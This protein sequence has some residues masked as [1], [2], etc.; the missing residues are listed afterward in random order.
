MKLIR[1]L[2]CALILLAAVVPLYGQETICDDGI[3]NDGDTNVDC[4]DFFDCLFQP[5]SDGV[6]CTTGET[7]R[8]AGCTG[9]TPDDNLCDDGASCTTDTCDAAN[10][11]QYAPNHGLC[12]DSVACTSPDLCDPSSPAAGANGCVNTPN[13]ALCNDGVGCTV[14]TCHPV[15]D[16][17]FAPNDTLCDDGN[18]CTQDTCNPVTDCENTPLTGP[19][20][21]D[22]VGCTLNDVCSAG[23]CA[24]TPDDALCDDGLPC[25]TDTCH[26]TLGCRNPPTPDGQ[27]CDDGWTCTTGDVCTGGVC[28]GTPD[29]NLCGGGASCATGTCDPADPQA[30]PDGCLLSFAPDGTPCGVGGAECRRGECRETHCADQVDNDVDGGYDCADPDDCDKCADPGEFCNPASGRCEEA[31]C[32]DR[33]DNDG[34]RETDCEDDNCNFQPCN[35]RIACTIND[36]CGGI[37]DPTCAGTPDNSQCA[38]GIACTRNPCRPNDPDADR[39]G[40]VFIPEHSRCDDGDP[41]TVDTCDLVQGCLHAPAREIC[42]DGVDNDCDGLTDCADDDCL[43]DADGDGHQAMPCGGDCDDN[44]PKVHPGRLENCFTPMDDDCDG[45]NN[46]QDPDCQVDADGDGQVRRPC[47]EDCDDNDPNNWF[48][49]QENCADRQDNNC[50]GLVDC[51]ELVCDAMAC[52]DGIVCTAGDTCVGGSCEGVPDDALCDDG[53][54]CTRDFCEPQF[55]RCGAIPED[56]LC[57]DGFFCNGEEVCEPGNAG[58][59]PLGCVDGPDPCIPPQVCD[60]INDTCDG[61]AGCIPDGWEPDDLCPLAGGITMTPTLQSRAHTL[62]PLG[63]V[64]RV[65]F[66]VEQGAEYTLFTTGGTDTQGLLTTENCVQQ[67]AFSN[68]CTLTDKNFCIVWT[69]TFTGRAVLTMDSGA[70]PAPAPLKGGPAAGIEA[71]GDDV[72]AAPVPR[73]ERPGEPG[74][75]TALQ[76]GGEYTLWYQVTLAACTPD[77]WEPDDNDCA[78]ATVIAPAGTPA[79][80]IHSICPPGDVDRF[81]FLGQRGVTYGFSSTGATDTR[82]EVREDNCGILLAASDDCQGDP[83][84]CLSF[85][86]TA[87]RF[88]TVQVYGQTPNVTGPYAFVHQIVGGAGCDLDAQE[89]DDMCDMATILTVAPHEQ[90]VPGTICP[91]G[92]VDTFRFFAEA[93]RVYTFETVGTTDLRGLLQSED[94]SVTLAEETSCGTDDANF[95]IHWRAPATG[96]YT[97]RVQGRHAQV[98]GEYLLRFRESGCPPDAWEPDNLCGQARALTVD[99]NLKRE[100]HTICPGTE[101]DLFKFFAQEG[102]IYRFFTEGLTDTAGA[103]LTANCNKFLLKNASCDGVDDNFCLTWTAPSTGEFRMGITGDARGGPYDLFYQRVSDPGTDCATDSAEP[104]NVCAQASPIL[105]DAQVQ[106]VGRT[107]CPPDDRDWFVFQGEA[108]KTYRFWTTGTTD[109]KG[110]VYGATCGKSLAWNDDCDIPNDLNFCITWTAPANGTYHLRVKG[111]SRDLTVGEY[112]LRYLTVP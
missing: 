89:P 64:D 7:C 9:G 60:E 35:D 13:D 75:T 103:V 41:C 22:G 101:V 86:P 28:A 2:F 81:R 84:F 72:Y 112:V 95:C 20:C 67:L 98:T 102:A 36:T 107:L 5:C 80:Q 54:W 29:D 48:G 52:D 16:C 68:D 99:F 88:Y 38:D 15:Q 74:E 69:A 14:D 76:G 111:L 23:L 27:P 108:G 78:T 87:T 63:D 31:V 55:G 62:C 37:G 49:N 47:G 33:V 73:A 109:T 6:S 17:Q 4:D 59:N 65:V 39:R 61:Q 1:F 66:D 21:N 90:G 11:C 85:T 77:A 91:E 25:T 110:G 106:S 104:D 8:F 83:N 57:Q 24:G 34:D 43:V 3:D 93:E 32:D 50:N 53:I 19:A 30:D 96:N 71:A 92:D 26:P 12:N 51:N 18:T 105:P 79:S 56:I 58:A 45:R 42:N 100:P 10:D 82:A 46:C 97:L 70:A 44:D 94:C 40:C